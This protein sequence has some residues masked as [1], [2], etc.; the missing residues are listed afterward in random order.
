MNIKNLAERKNEYVIN[1]PSWSKYS[2]IAIYHLCLLTSKKFLETPSRVLITTFSI[3]LCLAPDD[4]TWQY[5][6][7]TLGMNGLGQQKCVPS[8][9]TLCGNKYKP[10]FVNKQYT[11]RKIW[12]PTESNNKI[13]SIRIE[14]K[15][16][17]C[18]NVQKLPGQQYDYTHKSWHT[19]SAATIQW[20]M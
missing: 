10:C 11:I 7:E 20:Y 19:E 17:D 4:F 13:V 1:L 8:L 12:C 15:C 6:W 5:W 18:V 16:H 14:H 3:L 9:P 2:V